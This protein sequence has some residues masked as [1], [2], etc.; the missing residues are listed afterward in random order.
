[1]LSRATAVRLVT[2]AGGSI[3]LPAAEAV[4]YL[5]Q[6]GIKA[7]AREY[8]PDRGTIAEALLAEAAELGAHYLVAGAFGHSRLREAVIGGTTRDLIAGSKIPLFL[9][10]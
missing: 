1:M 7:E 6:Y 9:A 3:R 2:V 5:H 10:H 8:Q 4:H